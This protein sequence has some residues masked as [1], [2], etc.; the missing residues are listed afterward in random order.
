MST[1]TLQ[2]S[3]GLSVLF[4]MA[5]VIVV[6]AAPYFSFEKYQLL[7]S[8]PDALLDSTFYRVML[9]SHIG[10]G[11]IALLIG[12]SQFSRRL[13]QR[14]M[15]GHRRLG[16]IYIISILLSGLAGL[17]IAFFATGGW[18]STLGLLGLDIF[19]LFTTS[20]AYQK[21]RQKDI[22][23][24]R[25]WMV[26]SYGFTFAAVTLRLGLIL[27]AV[28]WVPFLTI[29]PIMC[30]ASWIINGAVVEIALRR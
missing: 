3:I 23:G 5:V 7:F 28:G 24:H 20:M 15:A 21:I 14:W 6:M 16:K 9:Y 12:P 11:M 13:R 22:E 27:A 17:Y 30:W 19:W 4:L 2:Q 8:K 1:N 25:R 10:L 29:Y 26:R 18:V